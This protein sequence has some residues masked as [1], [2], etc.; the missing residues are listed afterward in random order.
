MSGTVIFSKK[1]KICDQNKKIFIGEWLLLNKRNKYKKFN[2][3]KFNEKKKDK[4]KDFNYV[5][6]IY[7]RTLKNITPVLNNINQKNFNEKDWEIL[8]F[9]FLSNYIF[10]AYDKW[11]LVKNLKKSHNFKPI[12]IFSYTNN[13]FISKDSSNFYTQLKTDNWDDWLFS[14][15]IKAQKLKFHEKKI[16]KKRIKQKDFNNFNKL[17]L[18]RLLFP[19]NNNKYFLKNLALPRSL[20]IKLNL[21]LNKNLRFYND[22]N[23]RK[24]KKILLKRNLFSLIKSKDEFEKFIYN[25]LPEIFPKSYIE[26]FSFIEKNIKFLNWPKKPK[27]IFTSFD[28]YHN[29]AFKIYT[30]NKI[31][32]GAK[33]YILQHGHQGHHDFCG[34]YY[35]KK[36]CNK[37]FS[38]GNISKDNNVSSLFCTTNIGKIVKKNIK[39]DILLSYTEFSLKPWKQ[40]AYPRIMSETN[41]YKDDI[42]NLIN[43]LS[44]NLKKTITLKSFN[45]EGK[46][47]ITNEINKKFKTLD[48][49]STN[50]I[51]RGFEYSKNYNLSIETINSTG[52]IELLS[53]NTPVI[54][55]TNKKFFHVKKEYKKYYKKLIECN[56]IFFDIKKATKFI[57]FN[58]KNLNHWWFDDQTQKKIKYFCDHVCKYEGD[59]NNGLNKIINKIR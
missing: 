36:I 9:Y 46:K 16:N 39:K 35:E 38:W 45:S 43:S 28:H 52:F 1:N 29:D 22:I 8:I 30:I 32:E 34:T 17:K 50:K 5:K 12:E 27:I 10:F 11:K 54:L 3:L 20:K 48:F 40:Q 24:N 23:F 19:Q 18:Q 33:F 53:L 6:K 58:I 15:I 57:N 41:L 44:K 51:K 14:K 42:I 25:T 4:L 49:I 56:I 47:Y 59:F 55:I 13:Y 37:Y 2:V 21:K 31:K 7:K 26:N